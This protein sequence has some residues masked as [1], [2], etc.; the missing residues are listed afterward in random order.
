MKTCSACC[1]PH[2]AAA[3]DESNE[4]IKQQGDLVQEGHES[5]GF[6]GTSQGFAKWHGLFNRNY[7]CL[8]SRPYKN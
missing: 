5:H 8:K 4:Y 7:C 2:A 3:T 1:V 6:S